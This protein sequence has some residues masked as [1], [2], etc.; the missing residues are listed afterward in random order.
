M[1]S[2]RSFGSMASRAHKS[3]WPWPDS[4]HP[5]RGFAPISNTN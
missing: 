1:Q 4:L 3:R 2:R 5:S